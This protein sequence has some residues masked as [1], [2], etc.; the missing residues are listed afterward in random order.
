MRVLKVGSP[1]RSPIRGVNEFHPRLAA[2][3]TLRFLRRV[4]QFE[5]MMPRRVISARTPTL[6]EAP[7]LGLP[8]QVGK[9][10]LALDLAD[11]WPVACL[12]LKPSGN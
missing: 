9:T 11:M 10:T 3:A 4:P 7:A 5:R 12:D 1:W 6:A 8:C 2:G